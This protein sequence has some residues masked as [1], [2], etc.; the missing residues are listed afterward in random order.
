LEKPLVL[1]ADD[2][3]ATCTLIA[4]VL[5]NDFVCEVA[6]DG[7]EAIEKLR[8][9]PYDALLLDVLM[10]G[11]DGYAVLDHLMEKEPRLLSRVVV[12]TASLS[13][14]ELGRLRDYPIAR[15]IAKPFEV[16]VL[17][18]TVKEIARPSAMPE[19]FQGG[20]LLSG[21][22]LLLLADLLKRV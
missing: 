18:D 2:N 19:P 4:A 10:P 6:R 17:L 9:R 3:E 1:V 12:V 13:P 5:R 14:R 22:M 11:V 20:H 15:I 7:T 21:G 16:D 8:R